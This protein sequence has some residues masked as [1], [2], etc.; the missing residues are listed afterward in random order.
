MKRRV[1]NGRAVPCPG[2]GLP[3]LMDDAACTVRHPSPICALFEAKIKA[4]G[5]KPRFEPWDAV[6]PVAQPRRS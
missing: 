1:K 6:V 4:C 3:V 5:M 2:C